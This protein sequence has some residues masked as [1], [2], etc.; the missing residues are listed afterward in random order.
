MPRAVSHPEQP[1]RRG[2]AAAREPIAAVLPRE[3]DAELLEPVDRTL[4]V[5]GQDLDQAHV[6]ALVRALEDVSGVLLGRVVV[7]ERRLDAALRLGRV[8]GLDR[9]L[10]RQADARAGALGRDGRGEPEAPLPT[11]ST[12][13]DARCVT[14]P[15]YRNCYLLSHRYFIAQ[16]HQI[17]RISARVR[18][19]HL[20]RVRLA[21][22]AAGDRLRHLR[23]RVLGD[24]EVAQ[25]L[26]AA[27]TR[28]LLDATAGSSVPSAVPNWAICLAGHGSL[29]RSAGGSV[30]ALRAPWG[31][32]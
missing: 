5:A 11:T 30:S 25:A 27:E 28:E 22:R 18:R 1:L 10:R 20:A 29:K 2:A 12:S 21:L 13:K 32:P 8:A 7:A 16:A 26:E 4:R 3:L 14:A 31:A 9:A 6:G 19:R 15:G 17:E 24:A 23:R